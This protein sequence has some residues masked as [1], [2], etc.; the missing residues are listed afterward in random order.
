MKFGQLIECNMRNIFIEK[1]STKY[2]GVISFE[3][4]LIFLIK[5]FFLNDQ[6]VVTKT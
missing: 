5:P 4:N 2:G 6:K 3:V 1:S